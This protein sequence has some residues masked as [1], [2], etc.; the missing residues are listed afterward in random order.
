[1]LFSSSGQEQD[2]VN[3]GSPGRANGCTTRPWVLLLNPKVAM[4]FPAF[5][6]RFI[7]ANVPSK[8]TAFV[9]LGLTFNLTGT[10]WNLGAAG[11]SDS[12]RSATSWFARPKG[13][14]VLSK[15]RDFVG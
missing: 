8:V 15:I 2:W 9:I 6:P 3:C 10:L 11:S 14:Y 1:M 13:S 7:S 5:L 12:S 4:F